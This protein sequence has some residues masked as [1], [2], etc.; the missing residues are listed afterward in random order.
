MDVAYDDTLLLIQL[1]LY[2]YAP[3]AN[4]P[5]KTIAVKTDVDL[6]QFFFLRHYGFCIFLVSSHLVQ[7]L[8]PGVWRQSLQIMMIVPPG[9]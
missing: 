5:G 4:I 7:V 9:V 3:T 6:L 1:Q 8:I 2:M